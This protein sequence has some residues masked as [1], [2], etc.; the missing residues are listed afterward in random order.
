MF[1][2]RSSVPSTNTVTVGFTPEALFKIGGISPTMA[3]CAPRPVTLHPYCKAA[4]N[5]EYIDDVF[6]G[7]KD[8]ITRDWSVAEAVR[9]ESVAHRLLIPPLAQ[10]SRELGKY[11]LALLSG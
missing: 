10:I 4:I 8:K 6:R 11:T 2:V 9:V 3:M 5:T 1:R 7:P